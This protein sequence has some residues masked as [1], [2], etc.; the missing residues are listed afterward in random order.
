MS[1]PELQM[2]N[3]ISNNQTLLSVIPAKAGI[4]AGIRHNSKPTPGFRVSS[5]QPGMTLFLGVWNLFRN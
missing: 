3:E 5:F 4:Q 1:K 2:S